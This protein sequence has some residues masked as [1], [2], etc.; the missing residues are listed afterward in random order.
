MEYD[1]DPPTLEEGQ[2]ISIENARSHFELEYWGGDESKYVLIGPDREYYVGQS[3]LVVNE[4]N[5]I[6][7]G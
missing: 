7:D 5:K 1:T 6:D 3:E 4:V 2:T